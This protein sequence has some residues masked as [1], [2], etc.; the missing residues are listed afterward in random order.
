VLAANKTLTKDF[1]HKPAILLFVVKRKKL[2]GSINVVDN[3][4][5]M[6][7]ALLNFD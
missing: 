1:W 7:C 3:L 2:E 6:L 4:V 5:C